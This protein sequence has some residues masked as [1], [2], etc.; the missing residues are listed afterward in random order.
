MAHGRNLNKVPRHCGMQNAL[1]AT[2]VD[3]SAID[4]DLN[5]TDSR[6]PLFTLMQ[7]R[8]AAGAGQILFY[9]LITP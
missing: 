1:S 5:A 3:L 4:A 7:A 9:V 8:I 2:S 6:P